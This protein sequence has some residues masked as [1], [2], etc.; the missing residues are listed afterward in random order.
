MGLEWHFLPD[1]TATV[2]GYRN[3]FFDVNDALGSAA[4]ASEGFPEGFGEFDERFDGSS[5]GL[6]LSLRR[7]LTKTIGTY[8]SY[9]LGRS[10]RIGVRNT[11]PSGFD[12][13]HVANAAVTYNLPHGYRG[14]VRLLYYSGAPVLLHQPDGYVH[15]RDERLPGFFRFDWRGEK[16]WLVGDGWVS[17]VLEM[18]NAFF[19]K[20]V[21]GARCRGDT[22]VHQT[23]GPV[24][25]PSIGIEGG[26]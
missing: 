3:T 8:L 6:E 12:R 25:I 18:Q 2:T 14:S 20:E 15:V 21:I 22:C 1:W 26:L 24:T 9:A 13:T 23:F 19:A 10:E 7:R 16:R 4:I 17:L 5:L 11:F